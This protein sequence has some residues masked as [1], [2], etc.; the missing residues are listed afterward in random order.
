MGHL[1]DIQ[2]ALKPLKKSKKFEIHFHDHFF[3][4]AKSLK[5]MN[6]PGPTHNDPTVTLFDGVFLGKLKDIASCI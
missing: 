5:T 3:E 6:R 4:L 2:T 1:D